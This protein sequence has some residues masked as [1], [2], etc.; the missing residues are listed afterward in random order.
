MFKIS[1]LF[2]YQFKTKNSTKAITY[3]VLLVEFRDMEF[4][5]NKSIYFYSVLLNRIQKN[6]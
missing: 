2:Q 1:R 4:F 6:N 5:S 3:I